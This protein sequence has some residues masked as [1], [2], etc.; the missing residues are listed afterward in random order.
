MQLEGSIRAVNLLIRDWVACRG[1]GGP[2]SR[3]ATLAQ[4]KI[5]AKFEEPRNDV[6]NKRREDAWQRWIDFDGA[7]PDSGILGPH[8]AKARLLVH[9][10]LTNFRLGELTFTNGSS[11]EPLGDRTSVACKLSGVWTITPDC[12]DLFSRYS[13]WHRG[14]KMAVKKRFKR[15][16]TSKGLNER[17]V[18]R[19]LWNRFKTTSEP[20]FEIY[21]FKLFCSVTFVDGNRWST[22]PKNN[23][24]DRSICLE[25]LCNML[26][27]RAVG[28]GIRRCLKDNFGI[29]LDYLADVHRNRISHKVATI[30]LSDCSDA[31]SL[32]LIK[33][34]LPKRVLNKVLA[35]RS[36]M[37]LGPDD[38]Y[39]IVKKVSSM[40]N[41]FTFDLMTLVLTALTK[42]LDITSSVFGDDI[43]CQNQYA[44]EVIDNLTLAG[45][46]VNLDKTYINSDYRESCGAHYIDK[47]GYVTV[48]DLRWLRTPHDLVVA[49]NKVAILSCIYGEPFETLR[50]GIWS[51]VPRSLLG[52]TTERPVV[53]M[54]RPPSFD[55]SSYIRYGPMIHV[56][57]PKKLLR[58]L[59][60]CLK[61]LQK[62]GRV[63]VA[64][65]LETY[66]LPASNH[67]ASSNWDI[68]L[69]YIRNGRRSRKVPRLASKSTLVARVDGEQI[70]SVKALLPVRD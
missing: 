17:Q 64:L 1:S 61:M 6:A 57:P 15:Y 31:I 8:W 4:S 30:D 55:L 24:K 58:P 53:H 23:L 43:I 50:L 21:A 38:N 51:C 26:V 44:A 22:V 67:L 65:S 29:D 63:S 37:T 69:Q 11:F 66:Q 46:R 42:S 52:A 56:D 5:A 68:Y 34:L 33:Y 10:C 60:G 19:R 32:R 25:P 9:E 16:C 28:L 2:H 3:T 20:A 7:L 13:Y 45:F 70:G 40:G 27:Q 35:C 62:K 39:Y 18:N 36:D 12:F 49:C 47:Y 14:L 48:F 54:G 59:R 41:G